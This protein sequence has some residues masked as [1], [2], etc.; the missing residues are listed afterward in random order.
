M[1]HAPSADL[2]LKDELTETPITLTLPPEALE[3]PLANLLDNAFH[4]FGERKWGTIT[5]RVR[6]DPNKPTHPVSIEVSDQGQGMTAEQRQSLFTPRVS[7]K[8]I[9]GYGLGLYTS[10]QLL[11]AVGGDLECVESW[12]WLGSTFRIRLPYNMDKN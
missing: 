6:F 11:R 3:Q 2:L 12:R 10:R 1:R 7:A 9:Q 4:H 5:V 8:G